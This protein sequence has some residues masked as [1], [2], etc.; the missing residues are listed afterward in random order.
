MV[1]SFVHAHDSSFIV[2]DPDD[3]LMKAD[4]SGGAIALLLIDLGS[5]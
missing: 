3:G 2:I 1:N 4:G 5:Y